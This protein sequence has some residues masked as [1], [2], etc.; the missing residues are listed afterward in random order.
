MYLHSQGPGPDLYSLVPKA[1]EARGDRDAIRSIRL[2]P[3][4][5]FLP[6]QTLG[7]ARR[8]TMSD[9][10]SRSPRG[11]QGDAGPVAPQGPRHVPPLDR[12]PLPG[13]EVRAEPE[14]DLEGGPRGD[15]PGR[16]RA[17]RAGGLNGQRTR[18]LPALLRRVPARR[19]PPDRGAGGGARR[20]PD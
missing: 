17:G 9:G 5:R 20:A 16:A 18:R 1:S 8:R 19:L 7:A 6:V 12:G 2:V 11:R 14:P 4:P 3:G 10:P 13:G 15:A